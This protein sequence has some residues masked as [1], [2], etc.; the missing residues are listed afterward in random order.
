MQDQYAVHAD[1]EIDDARHGRIGI[2]ERETRERVARGGQQGTRNTSFR[3]WHPY[4]RLQ[5]KGLESCEPTSLTPSLGFH[6]FTHV[7]PPTCGATGVGD[8]RH[9]SLVG[10]QPVSRERRYGCWGSLVGL[11]ARQLT[12]LEAMPASI[13]PSHVREESSG[14]RVLETP[15]TRVSA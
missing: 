13:L 6:P 3:H 4:R 10:P 12:R 8:F 14:H 9:P 5:S 11:H 1:R 15:T 7:L 2:A